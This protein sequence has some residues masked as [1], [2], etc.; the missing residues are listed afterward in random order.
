MHRSTAKRHHE[1][2]G[3]NKKFRHELKYYISQIEYDILSKR[4]GALLPQ[5]KHSIDDRGYLIRSLYFD[6]IYDDDLYQKNYG[7]LKRKKIR[8]RTYNKSDSVIKLERKHRYG[9]YICKETVPITR[10]EYSK[11][12]NRD[13]HF[14]KTK[15]ESHLYRDFYLL[16]RSERLQPKVIVDYVREAYVGEE[17]D[18]RITFDKQLSAGINTHDLFNP[19]LVTKEALAFPELILEVKFN[20]YLPTYIRRVLNL[21]SHERSAISKY[22]ICR[23]VGMDFYKQ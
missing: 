4:I 22:V 1:L 2:S 14:L 23:E 19:N 6:N 10:D 13:F 9:E 12:C 21:D 20:E 11:L 7:V 5:D 3:L 18:V 15:T 16:L 8:I 17:S